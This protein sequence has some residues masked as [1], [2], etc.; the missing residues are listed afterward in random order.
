M[1]GKGSV[2]FKLKGKTMR[3]AF[4]LVELLIV[5]V[6][7]AALVG[8]LMPAIRQAVNRANEAACLAEI[9][10]MAQALAQFRNAYGFYP[11]SRIVVAEDG[12]YS[13]GNLGLAAPL[14]SR[15]TTYLKR[16][17]PRVV[18]Q[19]GGGK[20]AIPGGWYD[21]NGNGV[22]DSP[23]IVSGHECLALFLG[24]IPMKTD[25]GYSMMGFDRN[26]LNPFTSAVQPPSGLNWPYGS[27]RTVPLFDFRPGR[28][29][30][31]ASRN[32]MPAYTD[33]FGNDS[34]YVYF[35]SY[36]GAGYDPD[37]VN[38]VETDDDATPPV[39]GIMGGFQCG[40]AATPFTKTARRDLVASPA[41]NPYMSDTPFPVDSGGNLVAG[42]NRSR[43]YQMKSSY[44]II[45]AGRDRL[46][47]IGGQWNDSEAESLPLYLSG[48][49]TLTGQTLSNAVRVREKD[50]LGNF[51]NRRLD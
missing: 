8:L 35:S 12:D 19:S 25:N 2:G 33:Y 39:N 21:V 14:G 45:S 46:F 34:F 50:N 18:F 31:T 43:V 3:R 15:S 49:G 22:K 38:F 9:Q 26:P 36:Q 7:I 47:G 29:I 23:Y 11:P 6:V 51:S 5:I 17:F 30:A 37:D 42:D 48:N 44:Q 28:L 13:T 41:P 16:M 20:P 32:G 27:N 10:A 1:D 4:T 40:N 24:G